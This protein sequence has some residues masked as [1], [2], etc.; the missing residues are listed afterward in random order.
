MGGGPSNKSD[1]VHPMVAALM[2]VSTIDLQL[3]SLN[4]TNTRDGGRLNPSCARNQNRT[5][6]L[7]HENP[8]RAF[9]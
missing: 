5:K 3:M 6:Q 9:A 4:T 8:R 1:N 2:T 7:D